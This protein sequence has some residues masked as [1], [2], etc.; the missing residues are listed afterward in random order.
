MSAVRGRALSA[1]N[2]PLP[3]RTVRLRS[4]QRNTVI[5]SAKTDNLGAF[6]FSAA[7]PGLYVVELVDSSGSV[8]AVSPLVDLLDQ[9]TVFADVRLSNDK[10]PAGVVS[11]H[12]VPRALLIALAAAGSGLLAAAVVGQDSTP[13]R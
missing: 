8:L 11:S 4:L 12:K 1:G 10:P 9:F 13:V 2:D 7:R 3:A 5:G 6:E